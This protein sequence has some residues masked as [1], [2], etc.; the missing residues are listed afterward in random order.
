MRVLP[1]ECVA[2]LDRSNTI[3]EDIVGLM[4][5]NLRPRSGRLVMGGRP[6]SG[7][8]GTRGQAVGVIQADPTRTMIFEGLTA[9]DNLCFMADR[10][11]KFFWSGHAAR[12]SIAR[13]YASVFGEDIYERDVR[14]LSRRTLYDLVYYRMHL[15]R[16]A[17]VFCV[18]P[19]FGADM[20]RR[21]HIIDLL[22]LLR[23]RGIAL[24]LLMVN[25]SDS[26]SVADRLLVAEN[27]ALLHEYDREGFCALSKEEGYDPHR[28]R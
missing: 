9:L 20:Y 12:A 27:G 18:Q 14:R 13:E 16:P 1:G 25:I 28:T 11:G 6:F 24:V 2:L 22:E 7:G 10:K 3:L 26:L 15:Y 4:T 8:D 21:R 17:V 23:A 19:F 5:G